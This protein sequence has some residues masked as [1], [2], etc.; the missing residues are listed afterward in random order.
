MK[1]HLIIIMVN[2]LLAS[3]IG[4]ITSGWVG[5][6]I[7]CLILSLIYLIFHLFFIIKLNT[8]LKNP[9]LSTIP[10][11]YG[12][13]TG[14]FNQLLKQTKNRKKNKQKLANT[15]TRFEQIY[16]AMPNGLILL[17]KTGRMEF[18]NQSAI[19]QL[20]LKIDNDN[21]GILK[22]IIRIPDFHYFLD[23]DMIDVSIT[24]YDK[25]LLISK[26]T[27]NNKLLLIIQDISKSE[28]LNRTRSDFVANVSHELRTPLTVISGFTETLIEHDDLPN[29][30]RQEFLGLMKQENERMLSLIKDLLTL[31]RLEYDNGN[32]EK[33]LLDLSKLVQQIA[34]DTEQLSQDKHK[35]ITYIDDHIKILGVP[36]DI[37]NALSNLTF[38]AVKYTPH[39]SE[40]H[41]ILIKQSHDVAQF[42]VIDTGN[43]IAPEHLPR[44]TE[45]FYRVDKGRNR[46][47]GGTGLGL[48]ISKHALAKHGS[49]LRVESEIG[50]GS[51]F[52]ADF[53]LSGTIMNT[54]HKSITH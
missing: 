52:S 26:T 3:G 6:T 28:Q 48:A 33:Q 2:F 11:G 10:N 32:D 1:M 47:S 38:N 41:I 21:N 46:Q 27:I 15:I 12:I 31:S 53:Q 37:Y 35:I 14:I 22:N 49:Y 42:I 36:L 43:G 24:Y 16:Q 5:L 13:W 34:K 51:C 44:L 18:F 4:L 9:T 29:N 20:H 25:Q 40:I 7:Y 54:I 8:W 45:R 39:N 23:N 50:K 30:K 19:S 17:D